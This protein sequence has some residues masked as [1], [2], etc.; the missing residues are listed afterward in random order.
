MLFATELL[1]A[2]ERRVQVH[3]VFAI[4]NVSIPNPF[5]WGDVVNQALVVD[6]LQLLGQI[7]KQILSE[8]NNLQSCG[9]SLKIHSHFEIPQSLVA[10]L[11]S[12][13]RTDF[14]IY[15]YDCESLGVKAEHFEDEAGQDCLIFN[16]G[17]WE[18]S[19]QRDFV[20]AKYQ[21]QIVIIS[22][23]TIADGLQN[24]LRCFVP[25]LLLKRQQFVLHCSAVALNDKQA[26][27]FMGPSGVGKST[28]ISNVPEL[29]PL[30]DDMNILRLSLDQTVRIK[31]AELGSILVPDRPEIAKEYQLVALYQLAQNS[32]NEI[33]I[34]SPAD[35]FSLLIS[36]FANYFWDTLSADEVQQLTEAAHHISS[37]IP[38]SEFKNNANSEV[39]NILKGRHGL[40]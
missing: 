26:I 31:G 6:K 3:Q 1:T 36:N 29:V 39:W 10:L 33:T 12:S 20:A 4:P 28:I 32:N 19:I 5:N 16:K 25:R 8:T 24:A 34:L 23:S 22:D 21:R 2:A 38:I 15:W 40:G 37:L 11:H 30:H 13:V 35:T 14:D 7:K 27:A 17:D 18:F 9:L